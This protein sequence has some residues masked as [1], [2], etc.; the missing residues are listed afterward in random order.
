M[1][2]ARLRCCCSVDES[3]GPTDL[4]AQRC[5][6][7]SELD[8]LPI[9]LA[10]DEAPAAFALPAAAPPPLASLAP[11]IGGAWIVVAPIPRARAR[12]GPVRSVH[13]DCSVYLL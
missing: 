8:E 13:R 11:S 2:H 5:C 9:G 6:E 1:G 3:A 7:A 12:A 10:A 4:I